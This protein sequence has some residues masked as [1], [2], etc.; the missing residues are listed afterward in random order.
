[1]TQARRGLVLARW[2]FTVMFGLLRLLTWLIH[3]D[4]AGVGDVSAG[5]LHIHHYVWGILLLLAVGAHGPVERSPRG[6]AWMG[7]AHG[8]A[9]ALVVD[10]AA[11][12]VSLEDVYWDIEGGVSIALALLVIGLAGSLLALT[13]RDEEKNPD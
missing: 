1:M 12:L 6:R 7:L 8:V 11:L 13:R 2:G 4:V 10:E 5:G 9:A 3:I